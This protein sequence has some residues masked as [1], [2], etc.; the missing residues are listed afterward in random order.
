MAETINHARRRFIVASAAVGGG[1]ALGFGLADPALAAA[2]ASE[3]SPWLVIGTDGSVTVRVTMPEC[4]NGVLTQ[5][6]MTVAEELHCDWSKICTESASTHRDMFEG[7]PFTGAFT[8]P[9][10]MPYFSGRS[11]T[12]A[13]LGL[14]LQVGASARERLKQ[15]AAE[16]WQVPATDIEARDG[17][18]LHAASGRRLGFGE[19]AAR[20]AA[21]K[22]ATEPR[23]KPQSEWALLGKKSP[24][25]LHLPMIVTGSAEYGIDV[26]LPGMVYAALMQSPVT[27]GRLKRY[28]PAKVLAMPGV[29]AVVTVDPDEARPLKLP[30]P[31][32]DGFDDAQAGIA[33]I[34]DHYWQAKKALAALEV[35]WDD[36]PGAQWKTTQQIVDAAIDLLESPGNTLVQIGQPDEV[37]AGSAKRIEATYVTPYCEHAAM[38]PL[39][40]TALVTAERVDVWHPSQFSSMAHIVAAEETS[41]P[42]EKVFFHQTLIGG[43]FGRRVFGNDVRMVVAV[44]RKVPGTPVHVIWSREETTRQGR[45]RALNVARLTAGLDKDG[46]IQALVGRTAGRGLQP[47]S[48]PAEYLG[49]YTTA[50]GLFA[51]TYTSGLIPHSRVENRDLP[52]HLIAG[53]YRGPGYNSNAFMLESFVDEC[54]HAARIDPLE[55][56]LKLYAKWPDPGATLCLK[57]AAAKAGW[58]K[59]LKPGMGQGMAIGNWGGYGRPQAGTTVC[60]VATVEVSRTGQLTVHAIDL[61]FDCGRM[62]NR[63]AVLTELQGGVIFGLNM[64]MNEELNIQDGRIVEGNFDQYPMLRMGDM[65]QINI[66]FG[67]LSGHERF[68]EIGEPAVGVIGPAIANAIFRI[69]G[70]RIRS[71]PFRK[72]DLGKPASA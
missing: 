63:D 64:A 36:G 60:A 34:A 14:M 69:T 41:M 48:V 39:N 29:R 56:R 11:T 66:H 19:V 71:T 6:A 1:L 46:L 33:V 37:L 57:E 52:V 59:K 2:T 47:R 40:G 32:T 35:E 26:R 44:A 5:M 24:R 16:V 62:L 3:I 65:P 50:F 51:S 38:E 23:P 8:A 55:Y 15:A 9:D 13:W 30:K 67:G 17:N 21:V 54:A 7:R 72:H 10:A 70:K 27:G 61:A 58:G 22:L 45:Y 49:G 43:A 4:G 20:A 12:D 42:P 53:P 25:K 31:Y 68:A 28:D 18:L